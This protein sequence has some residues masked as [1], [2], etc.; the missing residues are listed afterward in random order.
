MSR[1]GAMGGK[2]YHPVV[3]ELLALQQARRVLDAPSG[4]GWLAGRMEDS[5]LVDGVDLYASAPPGYQQV[6]AHDLNEG[7]P[8]TVQ[9]GNYDAV[10]CCE[11]IEHVSNPLKL[12]QDARRA[13]RP[14]GVLIVTTPNTWYPTARLQFLLRGFL[15]SFPSLVGR[16]AAGTHMHVMPWNY[17]SLY[18]HFRLAGFESIRIHAVA[19]AQ[20]KH[21]LEWLL[22]WPSWLYCR[23]RRR[24]SATAEE[25]VFWRDAGSRA[26]QFGRQ[27]V[28]SACAP[29]SQANGDVA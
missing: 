21:W 11:G 22:G 18:L 25:A 1:V 8:T 5:V 28:L 13:L 16:I 3:L 17:A 4:D 10:V 29:S 20:P 19:G 15:P 23:R 24:L 26:S 27:L 2:S 12:L 14:G 7:L 6:L 9:R